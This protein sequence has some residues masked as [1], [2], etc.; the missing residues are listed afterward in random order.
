MLRFLAIFLLFFGLNMIIRRLVRGKM[1]QFSGPK[2]TRRRG[3]R[4]EPAD[5]EIVDDD[6]PTR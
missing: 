5:F 2:P 4:P 1:S 6:P 3:N